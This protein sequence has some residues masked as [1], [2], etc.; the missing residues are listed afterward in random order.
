MD[1]LIRENFS[2]LS[3]ELWKAPYGHYLQQ[4]GACEVFVSGQATGLQ[5]MPVQPRGWVTVDASAVGGP[6]YL[7]MV[8]APRWKVVF[9]SGSSK[10]DIVVREH[11]SLDSEE[12]AVLLCG[13]VVE[14]GG[15]QELLEDGIIRMPIVFADG[16]ETNAPA[17]AS[18]CKTGW[19]TCDA[20]S[21]G[22]PKFFE[23][24]PEDPQPPPVTAAAPAPGQA[25]GGAPAEK[26]AEGWQKNRSYKVLN[27][28]PSS[29]D[30]PSKGRQLP[31]LARA[32]PYA[33]GGGRTPPEDIVVTW[34]KND[35]VVEQT[36]HSKKTRG[37][38]VMPVKVT[39]DGTEIE[40]WVTRR[41]V[42]KAR[43]DG[44]AP[45]LEE[46]GGDGEEKPRRSRREKD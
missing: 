18:K 7:E 15:P 19:V 1:V 38:M 27:L 13:T 23:P 21:Q 24:C 14:Q 20:S 9:R 33:P 43:Q 36:G 16:K 41:L 31:I 8:R 44:E 34:L 46:I 11:L 5:R 3:K 22:G 26:K 35:E 6:K 4:G 2:L 17:Q 45:W 32:E 25:G 42:D 30:D 12:V 10:G 40:G 39:R 28:D 37:F 29:D